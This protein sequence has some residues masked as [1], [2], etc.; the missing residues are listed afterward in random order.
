LTLF[1]KGKPTDIR[2]WINDPHCGAVLKIKTWMKE[3][4]LRL[5]EVFISSHEH[6]TDSLMCAHLVE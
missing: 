6:S 5:L 3:L 2:I 1:D 4:S